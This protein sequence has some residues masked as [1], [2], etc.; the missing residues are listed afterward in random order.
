MRDVL[1]FVSLG[2]AVPLLLLTLILRVV[3]TQAAGDDPNAARVAR[4][5][6]YAGFL[7]YLVAGGVEWTPHH[8]LPVLELVVRAVI[9]GGLVRGLAAVLF[10]LVGKAWEALARRPER[11]PPVPPVL[12]APPPVPPLPPPPLPLM[13][14]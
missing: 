13:A 9:A 14:P 1:N 6:G 12:S 2:D 4:G 11:P 8:P 10:P 7:A 3:G 5:C